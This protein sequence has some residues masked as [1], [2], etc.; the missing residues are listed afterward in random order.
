MN[1]K[2]TC[3]N[4]G[5]EN[6]LIKN[7]TKI[8]INP[9]LIM[10]LNLRKMNLYKIGKNTYRND[11][12]IVH[13]LS[14]KK[15]GI[16]CNYVLLIYSLNNFKLLQMIEQNLKNENIYNFELIDFI[17][18]KN[19]NLVLWN[20]REILIYESIGQKYELHQK[21]NEFEHGT[22]RVESN[23]FF[24]TTY[25][26]YN[27]SC[28][29]ELLNSNLISG[30]SYGIKIYQN[31]NDE[32][33]LIKTLKTNIDV[34]YIVQI[35]PN[36]LILFEKNFTARKGCRAGFYS[37][38]ISIYDIDK[39]EESNINDYFYVNR[40]KSALNILIKGIYL[41]DRYNDFF[42]IYN[43]EKGMEKINTDYM[44]SIEEK[45]FG[46]RNSKL[47]EEMD[48]DLLCDYFDNLF[49]AKN[50][51]DDEVKIYKFEDEKVKYYCDFPIKICNPKGIVKLKNYM[52]IIYYYYGIN[53]INHT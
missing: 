25:S 33:A 52:L 51:N 49:L 11:I 53:I 43:I 23:I 35:K 37:H 4:N 29:Y 5:N 47:K 13:E 38:L 3:K 36:L 40:R 24:N 20:K 48:I 41:L 15:L 46:L 14:N 1:C 21:I 39:E 7:E 50:N 30:N 12:I 18:L 9:Q 2:S 27:I 17:E 45:P 6:N 26:Y 44:R 10:K 8:Q 28:V 42:D 32:Y 22:K 19:G 16:L 31:K 34:E